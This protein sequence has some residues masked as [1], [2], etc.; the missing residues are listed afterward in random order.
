MECYGI[1]GG[2]ELYSERA[3]CLGDLLFDAA[4]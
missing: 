4:L 2:E 1:R 3:E